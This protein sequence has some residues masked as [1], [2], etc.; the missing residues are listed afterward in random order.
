VSRTASV[1]LF[2][3]ALL[4]SQ[5]VLS[6]AAPT[7]NSPTSST[8]SGSPTSALR[9]D[10]A[11][12]EQA[13][14]PIVAEISAQ[15]DRLRERL[16]TPPAPPQP[17]RDPFRYGVRELP[18][19]KVAQ[20]EIPVAPPPPPAPELPRLIAITSEKTDAGVEWRAAFS[21]GDQILL[22]KAGDTIGPFAIRS[23]SEGVVELADPAGTIHKLVLQS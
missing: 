16:S 7:N 2:A 13:T 6:S 8:S 18:R 15:V 22:L 11:A 21:N 20:P 3:G 1:L 5:W 23:V 9:S 12:Y 17:G 19:P 4:I 10:L 14:A